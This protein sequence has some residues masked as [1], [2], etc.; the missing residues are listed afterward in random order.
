MK[1][2][3]SRRRFLAESSLVLAST[4][5]GLFARSAGT[6]KSSSSPKGKI[7]MRVGSDVDKL[8]IKHN[9][10]VA[11]LDYLD[12]QGLDGAFF[13]LMLDL[14]P[15]LDSGELKEIKAH[16]NSLGMFLDAGVGWMNPYNTAE[17]PD[18]RQFGDGDYRLAIEKM[19]KAARLIDCTELWAVS[20]HS[21]HG[22]PF[23][24]AYD[25]FRTDVSWGDQLAAMTKFI[26]SLAPLLRDLQLRINLETHGDETSF[27]LLRLIE[28][29]GPDCVGVTLDTG[30][31]PLEADLPKD[32][33]NRLA[34]YVHLTHCKDG[35]L[36]KTSQGIV[37]QIR[38][39]G[40]GVIDWDTA[41]EVLGKYHPD[42]HLCLE[43]YR[44]ENLLRFYDSKWRAHFPELTEADIRKFER[45]AEMCEQKIKREEIMGVNEYRKLP[46]G[47]P[48][49]ERSYKEG[50]AYLRKILRAKGELSK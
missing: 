41:I 20:A 16:A 27:E 30:N 10:P 36:Y 46:W 22:D 48:E 5:S 13:R 17:R 6:N 11:V 2:Q 14:S 50:A 8:A 28:E 33:I 12:S 40:E 24:V 39:L 44:T 37:Q 23:Y 38:T 43:D 47:E 1:N 26:N 19:L 32:A 15:T 25:R 9:S 45:L 18:I 3:K 35:I 4:A 42:L 29:V 21:V 7:N 34:P 49:R 31:L